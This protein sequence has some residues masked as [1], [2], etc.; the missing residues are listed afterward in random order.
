MK[1][2]LSVEKKNWW[3]RW[4]VTPVITQLTIGI[5]AERLA[6]TVAVGIVGGVFPIMGTTTVLCLLIGHLLKLNQPVMQ[7]AKTLVYPL[8][9]GLILVFIHMGEKLF[10]ASELSLSI[11]QLVL[12][13]KASPIQF[14]RDFSVAALHGVAAWALIAPV[15][16]GI[17][18]IAVQPILKKMQNSLTRSSEVVL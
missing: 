12:R 15:A 10:G 14:A 16:A 13:F 9:L 2:S 8:H 3:Y 1:K 18:K 11:P 4:V 5:S 7:I 6:W 17:I